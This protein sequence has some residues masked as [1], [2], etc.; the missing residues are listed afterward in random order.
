MVEEM[1]AAVGSR[2][3]V[4]G[5]GLLRLI[6]RSRVDFAYSA[7]MP[8]LDIL[9]T[10]PGFTL[11]AWHSLSV[12]AWS[13]PPSLDDV[14]RVRRLHETLAPRFPKTISTV[15]VMCNFDLSR[16]PA[17]QVRDA[18]AQ[19]MRDFANDTAAVAVVIQAGGLVG[20]I[21]RA[22]VAS[23]NLLSRNPAPTKVFAEVEPCISWLTQVPGQPAALAQS[24]QGLLH[25]MTGAM[26]GALAVAP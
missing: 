11:A 12:C 8:T 3:R 24:A 7:S 13:R 15:S 14:S 23:V 10:S 26:R 6:F 20:A 17:P 1:A 9:P 25:A 2:A 16:Q 18:A 5:V 21:G 4:G 19:L 22:F